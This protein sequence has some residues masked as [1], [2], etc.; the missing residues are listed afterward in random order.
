M[1]FYTENLCPNPSF[2][3]GLLG[4]SALLHS[5][6]ALD[7]SRKLY[8][9]AQS[10]KIV[11]PGSV[12]GE[13]AT[14]AGGLIE[15]SG[16]C[17]ASLFIQGAGSVSVNASTNPGGV[18]GT[19]PVTLTGTWQRVIIEN[20]VCTPGQTLFLTVYTTSAKATTFWIAGIQ[21]EENPTAHA[22]CDG[23]Q[24]GC[25][26][27]SGPPGLSVQ[28]YQFS[29][30]ATGQSYAA[31]NVPVPLITGAPFFGSPDAGQSNAF[32]SVVQIGPVSPIAVFDDFAIFE[33]VDPDPAQT[34]PGINN[35]GTNSGTGGNYNRIFSTFYAPLDYPVSNAVN[36]W[37]RAAYAAV[38]FQFANVPAAGTQNLTDVQIE[39]LPVNNNAPSAYTLPRQINTIVIPDRLNFCTNPGIETSTAGWSP[40][41]TGELSRDITRASPN[42]TVFDDVQTASTA[43]LK[44]SLH[45]SND[46]A[47][48]T[49]ADLIVGNT[50]IVSA[51]VQPGLGI[52][53]ITLLCGGGTGSAAAIGATLG[54]GT[55]GYGTDPYGGVVLTGADL[56]TTTWFR[57]FFVFTASASTAT[58]QV[59]FTPGS[60]VSYPTA[61]WIDDIMVELGGSL[62]PYFDGNF[63][64]NAF[65][66][67]TPNLSRSYFYDQFFTKQQAVNNVL[68]R[69]TPLGISFSNPQFKVPYTQL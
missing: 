67:G 31:G 68:A 12:A 46:G 41:N 60:D 45:N 51:Y 40:I 32:S 14:T 23:D 38:G 57:P 2:Q 39:I 36:E 50:Y 5:S 47:Q 17:S 26:W 29:V 16:S 10:L 24:R 15:T 6:I 69:H 7:T 13:G 59:V 37:N 3:G 18:A 25:Y 4:Y 19:V 44:V 33:S 27:L 49:I 52:A 42:V 48:I 8:G 9:S 21:I 63:G 43:S 58:L 1:A 20:I 28:P 55:D 64:P 61:M 54:Y 34:Y 35:A 66:E 65:W 53:N 11:T 56:S 62:Q 22:Y 30:T